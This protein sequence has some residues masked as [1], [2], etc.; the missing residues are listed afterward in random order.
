MELMWGKPYTQGNKQAR[1]LQV[2]VIAA[3]GMT[4]V[5]EI[6]GRVTGG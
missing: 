4:E 3:K 6:Q 1:S 5:T 2:V